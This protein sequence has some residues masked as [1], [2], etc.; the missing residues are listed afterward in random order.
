MQNQKS[1]N[2]NT[3][4]NEEGFLGLRGLFRLNN[5]GTVE[6]AHDIKI[7]KNKKFNINEKAKEIF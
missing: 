4:I 1:L 3:L 6:R 2:I 7:I 5:N